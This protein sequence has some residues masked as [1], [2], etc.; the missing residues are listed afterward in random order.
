[1]KRIAI[2][3]SGTG[4][5]A[6]NIIRYFRNHPSVTV[7]AIL[8]NNPTAGVIEIAQDENVECL[9]FSKQEL[10]QTEKVSDYLKERNIDLIVLAGFLLLVPEQLIR[11]FEGKIIN[12]HPALLPEFGGKGMYGA[13]VHQAV[14]DSGRTETGITIHYVNARYD[15][16][17]II[18]QTSCSIQEEDTTEII[19]SKVHDLE[20][21]YYPKIIETLL[22]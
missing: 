20:Y 18:F 11:V 2:F 5:N 9:V 14:K 4:T 6:R 17:N 10:N 22:T 16:G 1:M 13:K 12:I 8:T 19:A 21:E 3:A 7:S 15:E